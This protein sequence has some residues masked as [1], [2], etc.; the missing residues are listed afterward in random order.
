MENHLVH[1][2]SRAVEERKIFDDETD[3]FRYIFQVYSTNIGKPAYNLRRVDII[4]IAQAI[5]NGEKISSKF[6]LK[7]HPPLVYFLDFSLVVNHSHFYLVSNIE[8]GT[9]IFMRNL[10]NGFAK[11]FNLKYGRKGALFGSRY[12]R[13]TIKDQLQSDAVSRYVGVINP[14]DIFQPGW[15]ENGLE[16]WQDALKFLEN[17]QFSSFPDKIGKRKSS[18]LAPA[19]ILDKYL[20]I[21]SNN[22]N[23]YQEFVKDFLKQRSGNYSQLF[24]E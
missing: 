17:Y 4:K 15:R 11:Y 14:L 19:D 20:S 10:N 9:A 13:I 2:I 3:C 18:I 21:S 8:N 24:L 7:E 1:V 16:N 6:I 12:K 23:D 22:K 5:L